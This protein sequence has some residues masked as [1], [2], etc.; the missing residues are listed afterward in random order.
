MP[1]KKG[2]E[3]TKM[4]YLVPTPIGNLGDFSPRALSCLEEVDFLAVED[5]RV[6]IKLLNHFE[7]KKPMVLYH[8]HNCQSAGPEIIS[9]LMAGEKCALVTDAGTPAISDP[10]EDLVREC[11]KAEIPVE[12]IPG[13]CALVTALVVSGLETGRF[14]FEGFLS[15]N[16]KIRRKHLESLKYEVR[17]MIFYEAPHKLLSTL[18]DFVEY[19]GGNRKIV[20]CRE[21]SK[22]HEEIRRCTMEEALF[23][24]QENNPRGEFVLVLEGG[25]AEEIEEPSLEDGL[26]LVEK[27]VETGV[28]LRDS[29]KE[30]AKELK[31]SRNQL[32][33]LAV[34]QNKED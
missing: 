26:I 17:T 10:G 32:Y 11:V 28:S 14:T 9:R 3:L 16:K 2:K 5:S 31:L 7:I 33:K 30:V 1:K 19:F 21:L 6:T 8:R 27:A 13:A 24:Y 23:H 29:V 12:A 22:K 4:L 34:E 20:L 18:A 15:M 25:E